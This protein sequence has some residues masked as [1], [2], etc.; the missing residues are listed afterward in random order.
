MRDYS[1]EFL[2]DVYK[3]LSVIGVTCWKIEELAL[4]QLREVAEV[5]YT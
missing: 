1:L 5:W 2:D 4:Y 3:V